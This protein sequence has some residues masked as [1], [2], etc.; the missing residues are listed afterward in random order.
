MV[1]AIVCLTVSSVAHSGSLSQDLNR[2]LQ[3]PFLRGSVTGIVVQDIR[4]HRILFANNP[5]TRLLPASNAKLFVATAALKYLGASY[6]FHTLLL[7][8]AVPTGDT[9]KGNVYLR[10]G[11]DPLLTA[12]DVRAMVKDL[13]KRGVTHIT[14]DI[15]GDGSIFTDGPY[16]EGWQWDYL[17]DDYAPQICG[18]EVEQGLMQVT[19]SPGPKVGSIPSVSVTPPTG[20]L[21]IDNQAT[22]VAA[23]A[24]STLEITR[25][26][27]K[28]VLEVSGNMPIGRQMA[29]PV[30]VGVDKPALYA[31]T[32]LMEDMLASG[33][34]VDGSV[35]LGSTSK[36]AV[37]LVDHASLPLKDYLPLMLKPSNNLMAECL[38]RILGATTGQGGNF[39]AGYRVE[40]R[41]L[42]QLGIASNEY[43]LSDGSGVTRLDLVTASALVKLLAGEAM[44]PNFR[45]LYDALPVGGVDGTLRNRMKGT[46]A[47]GNV[48]AKTGTLRY[49][50][51]LSG[52][53][54]DADANIL[55]FSILNNAFVVDSSTIN[56]FQ[57]AVV[58][59]L[60][61][62]HGIGIVSIARPKSGPKFIKP[63]IPTKHLMTPPRI[64]VA[65]HP[66]GALPPIPAAPEATTAIPSE[67]APTMTI[68][69]DM[70]ST[71][72]V[73]SEPV[74]N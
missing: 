47:Q 18:L 32:L 26:F 20:Y 22:T 70:P 1:A 13:V 52:Y 54:S 16:P 59:R 14:G 5:N 60:A 29:K 49:A 28:N 12:D 51:N 40:Q 72:T 36:T 41:L 68:P 2:L 23:N 48:H 10:G 69:S 37:N 38:V 30:S 33:I 39:K 4:T 55:A 61:Q 57:D 7:S 43:T 73:P 42:N 62:E 50:H 74:R 45:I 27:D 35:R 19:V 31:T 66:P 64:K 71:T 8:D 56:R 25:P 53:V 6:Q 65:P 21:P 17:T 46:P 44:E 15:V 11:G 34:T 67:P 58:A 9:I 63:G 24:Q 3:M